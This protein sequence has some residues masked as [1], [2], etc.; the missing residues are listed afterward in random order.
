MRIATRFIIEVDRSNSESIKLA[1]SVV[2]PVLFQ[3]YNFTAH[4]TRAVAIEYNGALFNNALCS[5]EFV[6][7]INKIFP[8]LLQIV[9]YK[10][11]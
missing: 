7:I 5:S 4:R 1:K 8:K 2:E 10:P 6:V 11:A 9:Y 3:I